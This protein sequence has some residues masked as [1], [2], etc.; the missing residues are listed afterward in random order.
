MTP[1]IVTS[2]QKLTAEQRKAVEKVA[3]D[4]LGSKDFDLQEVVDES[5]IAGVRLTIGSTVY[6]ASVRAKLDALKN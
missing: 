2:T 3:A 1:V 5:I 4:K 6:D